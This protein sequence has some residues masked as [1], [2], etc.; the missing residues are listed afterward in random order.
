MQVIHGTITDL[1]EK[2]H[3]EYIRAI[4]SELY[5]FWYRTDHAN[6]YY[7]PNEDEIPF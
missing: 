6:L 1:F 7:D 5:D 2:E 3:G 4:E